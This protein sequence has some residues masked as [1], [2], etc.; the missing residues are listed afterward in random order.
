MT[1]KAH[2]VMRRTLC[3]ALVVLVAS[4]AQAATATSARDVVQKASDDL[5][6]VIDEGKTYFANDPERFYGKVY[7]V[8]DPVIDF[9]SFARG[10]MAV[11]GKRATPEQRKRFE[12]TFK[13]GL[14]RTYGKALLDFDQEQV[15]LLPEDKAP[16]DPTK[17]TIRMEVRTKAGK[18]YPVDYAMAQGSDGAWRMR[19]IV[20]NG[21]NI[22]L[23]YRNQ[24]ASSMK[25][26][27]GDIDK[28]IA[29]WAE[30][31]AHVDPV[32]GD[33]PAQGVSDGADSK[34]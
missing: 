14:V 17:P 19:N 8:L 32:A 1:M 20:I 15:V 3:G 4:L 26:Q 11:Y 28:V 16:R 5:V 33:K 29:G 12:E 7:D 9:E 34:G 22:G 13:R 31:I 10:V 24:F 23:T 25:L 6:K 30:T 21:I 27:A 2:E 18:V